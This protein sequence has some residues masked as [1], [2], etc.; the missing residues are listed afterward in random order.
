MVDFDDYS[1]FKFPSYTYK[2][3]LSDEDKKWEA[4]HEPILEQEFLDAGTAMEQGNTSAA[5]LHFKSAFAKMNQ[6]KARLVVCSFWRQWPLV[7]AIWH[8]IR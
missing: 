7:V 4:E 3:I 1:D 2:D 5:L 6:M 8:G